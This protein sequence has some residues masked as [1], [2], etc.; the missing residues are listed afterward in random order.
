M[1][2]ALALCEVSSALSITA[3]GTESFFA[4]STTIA[5]R[6]ASPDRN[7]ERSSDE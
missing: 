4:A 3:L 1:T 6:A 7:A 5:S 2:S